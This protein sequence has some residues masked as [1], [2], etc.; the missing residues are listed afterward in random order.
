MKKYKKN[1][2]RPYYAIDGLEVSSTGQVRRTYNDVRTFT[3]KSIYPHMLSWQT[4]KEGNV[5]VRTRDHGDLLVD[6]LVAICFWGRPRDGRN[7]LIHKDKDKKNC[8]KDNLKW[9]TQ[10]EFYQH[11][12]D[13]PI[14]NSND[15]FRQVSYGLYV[16]KN[17]EVKEKRNGKLMTVYDAMYD[18]DIDRWVPI[19][20]HVAVYTST[21]YHAKRVYIDELVAEAYLP[22]PRNDWYLGLLHKD[23]NYKNCSLDNL[24]WIDS[25]S[26]EYKK[27]REQWKKDTDERFAELNP[28]K[29]RPW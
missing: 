23:Y 26:D 13:D 14:I 2:F 17:G 11:Y 20:P 18:A 10:E 19:D 6:K 3:G 12:A 21:S 29:K 7:Y 9:T 22:K 8:S 16:S 28:G 5:I 4:D 1:I 25:S 15:G 24:E 27:Y